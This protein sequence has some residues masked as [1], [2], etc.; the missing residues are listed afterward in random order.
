MSNRVPD[1]TVLGAKGFIGS[2]MAAHL[3][4][5]GMNCW[6]PERDDQAIFSSPLGHVIYAIGLTADFRTRPFDTV[7]AHVCLLSK[8]LQAGNFESLLFLSSTRVYTASDCTDES[9]SLKISAELDLYNLSKLMGES[10]CLH[11]GRSNVRI[12]RLSNVVGLRPDQDIFI[13][14]LLSEGCRTG[15]VALHTTL[16]S[17]KDYIHV[18]DLIAL[19]KNIALHGERKIYNAA[20]GETVSNGTIAQM[21]MEH[22]GIKTEVA[23]DAVRW[24]FVPI[25]VSQAKKEFGFDPVSFETY[26]PPYITEF[27]LQFEKEKNDLS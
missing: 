9:A 20:S 1:F 12:A 7:E 11:S 25:N 10:L 3:R 8:L 24:N 19:L 21:M 14:Q 18:D 15:R 16:D 13:D 27:K 2:R 23:S 6:T 4:S 17:A 5:Q 22:A 26:F